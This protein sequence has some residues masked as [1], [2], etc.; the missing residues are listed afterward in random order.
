MRQYSEKKYK[1]M[2]E[3]KFST[4][5]YKEHFLGQWD[6]GFYFD[7]KDE[8]FN[9]DKMI[10]KYT[11]TWEREII[12]SAPSWWGCFVITSELMQEKF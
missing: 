11:R 3:N 7:K 8:P 1:E 9:Q 12:V 10:V 2:L 5:T 4:Q 6:M